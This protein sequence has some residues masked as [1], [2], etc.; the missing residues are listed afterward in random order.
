MDTRGSAST[1]S[2]LDAA[3]ALLGALPRATGDAQARARRD[4]FERA[5]RRWLTEHA[6]FAGSGEQRMETLRLVLMAGP[7]RP[8][9]R[10]RSPR[11]SASV[12]WSRPS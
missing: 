9:C 3:T 5:Y 11:S 1:D 2:L 10:A 6:S 4:A 8:T 7:P 12:R